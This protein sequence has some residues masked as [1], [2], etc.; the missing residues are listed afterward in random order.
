MD[1][2]LY[3]KSNM[4]RVETR[5]LDKN[6]GVDLPGKK[7]LV[8]DNIVCNINVLELPK[9]EESMNEDDTLGLAWSQLPS[10][11]HTS[12]GTGPPRARAISPP[13]QKRPNPPRQHVPS[14]S[15]E[16]E[17][18]PFPTPDAS[19][20]SSNIQS[21]SSPDQAG[22]MAALV[23]QHDLQI[24]KPYHSAFNST[25]LLLM[26]RAK[27]IIELYVCG[28]VTDISLRDTV[29]DAARYGIKVIIVQDC[30]GYRQSVGHDFSF[31]G[32]IDMVGADVVTSDD[33]TAALSKTHGSRPGE[34]RLTYDSIGFSDQD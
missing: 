5:V 29:V 24:V 21:T 3:G 4:A 30:L 27:F 31:Q 8:L 18:R 15:V 22:G 1:H 12:R 13:K 10:D 2:N 20:E 23:Q 6:N 32:L 11:E 17:D 14:P 26:L 28:F 19:Y 34:G 16:D 33:I 25:S 7:G 9:A